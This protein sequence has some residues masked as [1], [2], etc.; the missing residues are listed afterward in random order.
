M[1]HVY[2]I[3]YNSNITTSKCSILTVYCNISVLQP[4]TSQCLY[5]KKYLNNTFISSIDGSDRRPTDATDR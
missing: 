2:I 1:Y 3:W 5:P 4:R